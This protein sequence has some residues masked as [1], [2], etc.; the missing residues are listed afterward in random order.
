M[1]ALTC[2]LFVVMFMAVGCCDKSRLD[3]AI[4]SLSYSCLELGYTAAKAGLTLE[5]AEAQLASVI[6]E[7]KYV[8]LSPPE[9]VVRED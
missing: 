2:V 8:T 9:S 1:K 7:R 4:N 5:E 3:D 6:G